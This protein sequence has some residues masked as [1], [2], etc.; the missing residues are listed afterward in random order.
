MLE[1]ITPYE[2]EALERAVK[3]NKNYYVMSFSNLGGLVM[4]I[5]LELTYTNGKKEQL[6]LPAEIWRRSPKKV[7]KLL[8]TK[9]GKE[10][11]SI[12]VDP[13]WET[14]DVDVENN[15]YP[16]RIVPSR[17]EAFKKEKSKKPVGRDIMNDI[18]TKIKEP[19]KKPHKK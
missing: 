3:E 13:N 12:V 6:M 17:I 11:E 19:K 1:D 4:P 15:H 9:K 16:R 18:K 2:R 14:A 7:S 8:I 10:L 5:L